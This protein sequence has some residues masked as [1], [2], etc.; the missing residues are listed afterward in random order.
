MRYQIHV[1]DNI[2]SLMVIFII[3]IINNF[4]SSHAQLPFHVLFFFNTQQ[5][6]SSYQQIILLHVIPNSS[7]VA[8]V[9]CWKPALKPGWVNP[10]VQV[11]FS[12]GHM[13]HWVKSQKTG[14]FSNDNH[15]FRARFRT[16]ILSTS[17][18]HIIE[19]HFSVAC[20]F[21]KLWIE[22]YCCSFALVS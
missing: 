15:G 16:L 6:L 8:T 12:L 2:L 13:G 19:H 18:H 20:L 7:E 5:Q 17:D 22:L 14:Y 1:M 21:S 11:T 10:H 9:L 4:N 3:A